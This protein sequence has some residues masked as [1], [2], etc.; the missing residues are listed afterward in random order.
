MLSIRYSAEAATRPR[1]A[2]YAAVLANCAGLPVAQLPPKKKII[3]GR[4]S[5]FF[6][7]GGK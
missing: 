6:H 4:R 2:K 7:P 5:P 3:A 1:V